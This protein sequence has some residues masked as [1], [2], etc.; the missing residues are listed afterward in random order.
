MPVQTVLVPKTFPREKARRWVASHGYRADKIDETP[1]Y[2]RFRQ[3]PPKS[4]SWRTATLP[5]GVL[6]VTLY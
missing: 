1:L 4:G 5:N 6:L 2:Y 3:F